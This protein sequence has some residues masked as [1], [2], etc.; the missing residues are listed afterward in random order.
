MMAAIVAETA[1]VRLSCCDAVFFHYTAEA[2]AVKIENIQ[3]IYKTLKISS[4]AIR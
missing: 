1:A 3:L 2:P 4:V